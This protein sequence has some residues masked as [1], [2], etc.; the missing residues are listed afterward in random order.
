MTLRLS[1]TNQWQ[2]ATQRMVLCCG[3]VGLSFVAI[4]WF[5]LLPRIQ[6]SQSLQRPVRGLL[7]SEACL[8]PTFMSRAQALPFGKTALGKSQ[9]GREGFDTERHKL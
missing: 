3:C 1:V 2:T 8:S 9:T 6:A 5:G 4:V 7:G